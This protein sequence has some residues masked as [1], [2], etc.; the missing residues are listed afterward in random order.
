MAAISYWNDMTNYAAWSTLC[1]INRGFLD[2][3]I[4]R[5]Q[6]LIQAPKTREQHLHGFLGKHAHLFFWDGLGFA[7]VISK[8]RFG[9]DFVADFV[10]VYDNWSDG[11]RYKLIEIERPE[12]PPFTKDGIASARLS[13]AI[14]QVLSWRS[15]LL[16]HTVEAQRLFPSYFHRTETSPVFEYEIIIGTR[17]NTEK[18][19]ERRRQ[20]SEALGIRIRSFDALTT[21]IRNTLHFEDFSSIGDEQY[22]LDLEKRNQLACPFVYALSDPNWRRMVSG[23]VGLDHFM[24]AYAAKLLEFRIENELARRFRKL[25]LTQSTSASPRWD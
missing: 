16:A 20:L 5:W 7:A 25:C 2:P 10:V 12:T 6:K 18:W 3:V 1:G 23:R 21:C 19:L 24:H 4:K 17:Q 14:Q 22:H 13:G 11:I 15:W 9:A 8:L